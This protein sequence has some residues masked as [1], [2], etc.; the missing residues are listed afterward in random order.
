MKLVPSATGFHGN[1]WPYWTLCVKG[2]AM[3][4]LSVKQ[5]W[6]VKSPIKTSRWRLFECV[7]KKK[8]WTTLILDNE[9]VCIQTHLDFIFCQGGR[10]LCGCVRL[11]P[12]VFTASFTGSL[13]RN[14]GCE[15]IPTFHLISYAWAPI[16]HTNTPLL[17]MRLHSC[18]LSWLQLLFCYT[19]LQNEGSLSKRRKERVHCSTQSCHC[20]CLCA[21]VLMQCSL[22]LLTLFM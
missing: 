10:C 16:Q 20:A 7:D 12:S 13:Y 14:L 19:I 17:E 2:M 8:R 1:I 15:C 5:D 21:A 4:R 3:H 22:K 11:S 9:Y 6:E 18:F